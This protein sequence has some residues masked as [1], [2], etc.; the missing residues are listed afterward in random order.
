MSDPFSEAQDALD[1]DAMLAPTP[2]EKAGSSIC[3]MLVGSEDSLKSGIAID[4]RSKKQIEDHEIVFVIDLDNANLPIW[5]EHWDCSEDIR[6]ANPAI[7][8]TRKQEDGSEKIEIDYDRT[9]QRIN[10]L[11]FKVKEA[12]DSGKFKLG[13][14]IFDGVD[15]LLSSAE[16][17]MRT[18][19][20]LDVDDGVSFQYWNIR[21]KLFVDV[22]FAVKHLH[23]AKYFITHTKIYQKKK[24]VNG[25]EQVVKEWTEGIWEKSMPNELYQIIDCRKEM[26]PDGN[27]EY[28]AKVREFKGRPGLI[29]KEFKTMRITADKY[30][31]YGMPL[32]RDT[33]NVEEAD[34]T[35]DLF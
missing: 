19:R 10:Q 35:E 23:C 16:S 18:Q 22:V 31:F 26:Y 4:C 7:M 13:G 17:T 15:K 3:A 11:I 29:G 27:T 2:R 34:Y 21:K 33:E 8:V 24:I 6:L 28:F 5:K 20:E 30:T 25:K 9:I 14:F 1:I 32:L 12:E